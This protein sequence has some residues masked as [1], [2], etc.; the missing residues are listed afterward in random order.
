MRT[1][2]PQVHSTLDYVLVAVLAL[3][4]LVFG[5]A[6]VAPARNVFLIEAGALL[7]Y[8]LLGVSPVLNRILDLGLAVFLLSAPT[9]FGYKTSLTP[10]QLA[11][12]YVPAL[13]LVVLTAL[14]RG[15]G[16]PAMLE[17]NDEER[18]DRQRGSGQVLDLEKELPDL[19]P[20]RPPARR[21]PA[22]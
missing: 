2:P 13:C 21:K 16:P 12:H 4:P 11:A 18:A 22:A 15:G 7:L 17:E 20:E 8:T 1:I 9:A 10:L 14:S 5:F 3:W 19:R 6:H